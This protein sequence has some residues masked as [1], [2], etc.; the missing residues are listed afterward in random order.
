MASS[1]RPSPAEAI[2]TYFQAAST[3]ASLFSSAT[4]SAE[5]TVVTSTA[6]HS[7]ARL[8]IIGPTSIDQPNTLNS[9]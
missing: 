7:R 9:A 1:A 8:F 4:S 6:I 5:T 2:S 3:A